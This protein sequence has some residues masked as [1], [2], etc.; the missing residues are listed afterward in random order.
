MKEID[1]PFDKG[2]QPE[3]TLRAW[4]RTA[5]S[6]GVASAVGLRLTIADFG[7]AA[8]VIGISGVALSLAAYIGASVRYRRAHRSLTTSAMLTTGGTTMTLVA[9][10]GGLLAATALAWVVVSA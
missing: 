7:P 8:V 3:R 9:A 6:M 10:A 4:R 1:A 5:L 2:L